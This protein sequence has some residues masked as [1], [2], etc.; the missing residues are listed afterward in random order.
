MAP[1][2]SYAVV[3]STY[4]G[5]DFVAEQIESI[6]AQT[7]P[8]W[9]L[10][11]RDD[12]SSD[13]TCAVLANCA[14]REPRIVV[15]SDNPGNLG[16]PASFGRLLAHAHAWGERYVFLSDQDDVWLPDKA[17]RM[18]GVALE[19]EGC[20]GAHVPLLVHSD[21]RV[22]AS[23]LT[24][25][26]PS[27]FQFQRIDP[28]ADTELP[29]LAL[30]NAVTGCATLVNAALLECAL[31][32]PRVA[33]HDWWLAQCAALFG[34]IALVDLPTV[35]YRQHGANVFGA[36]GLLGTARQA[37]LTPRAWWARGAR[38]F[39]A[40]LEQLWDLRRRAEGATR[41]PPKARLRALI[42]LHDALGSDGTTALARVRAVLRADASPS[43]I[44]AR[45]LILM[46]IL[47]LPWLRPR[48]AKA[49]RPLRLSGDV[50]VQPA[51]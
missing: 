5:A 40:A 9:R 33:M 27:F 18:L 1:L 26:H 20:L 48:Y 42:Q 43:G 16:A 6:R 29:R 15:V 31:P 7:A 44:P 12:G 22:V 51:R 45:A 2:P 41:Q 3:L 13:E 25:V 38:H 35:L 8:D 46:W 32:F 21:L 28:R 47:L 34:H 23:D 11:V 50:D 10:Y 4:N 14:A 17:A 24:V 37:V 19:Y 39:V 36:K 30:R 49:G